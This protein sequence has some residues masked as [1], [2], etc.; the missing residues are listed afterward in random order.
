MANIIVSTLSST[1]LSL[2]TNDNVYIATTGSLVANSTIS[3]TSVNNLDVIVDGSLV[4]LA[5]SAMRFNDVGPD[6]EISVGT[7]GRVLGSANASTIFVDSASSANLVMVNAGLV[8]NADSTLLNYDGTGRVS[9]VNSGQMLSGNFGSGEGTVL[10]S[11]GDADVLN[12]GQLV[13][14]DEVFVMGSDAD[15][16][17][18][19][20]G[21][22]TGRVGINNQGNITISNTGTLTFEDDFLRSGGSGF[23]QDHSVT[24]SGEIAIGGD[25]VTAGDSFT[26]TNSGSF[27]AAGDIS[28]DGNVT[29]NN[30]GNISVTGPSVATGN[31]IFIQNSGS[32]SHGAAS[33][34]GIE[35]FNAGSTG[36]SV[37]NTG[38]M[39]FRGNAFVVDNERRLFYFGFERCRSALPHK[40]R[41]NNLRE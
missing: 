21:S 5:G 40:L 17:L 4:A 39:S 23:A 6:L 10:A 22:I 7:T 11:V 18:V 14:G 41:R 15:L 30:S 27:S 20:S 24:N 29:L 12:S 37:R 9:L 1:P 8:T 35:A 13:A 19:N 16:S 28:V 2:G 31:G 25:I 3:A 32:F 34:G 33:L 26:L 36:L 38:E